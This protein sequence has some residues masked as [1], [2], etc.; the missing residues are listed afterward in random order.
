MTKDLSSSVALTAIY[1]V[2]ALV[3]ASW[4][5][6]GNNAMSETPDGMTPAEEG[7][8]DTEEGAAYGLCVSYCEATDCAD[9]VQQADPEACERLK[10]NY[11]RIADKAFP[12]EECPCK[13][14]L[15]PPTAE[16]LGTV[17]DETLELSLI[18]STST[19]EEMSSIMG[20]DANADEV[21]Y[22]DVIVR[23]AGEKSS[24]A[25]I[26]KG[27]N[28]CVQEA[29]KQAPKG[30]KENPGVAI[31]ESPR[32]LDACLTSFTQ[33]AQDAIFKASQ[34]EVL[35]IQLGAKDSTSTEIGE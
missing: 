3:L 21:M 6:F 5:L 26:V 34:R 19:K 35:V 23:D 27:E 10:N 18:N 14:D 22:Q 32:V 24:C 29:I 30:T 11:Q 8:C 16:C 7:I 33:Y 15:V 31:I 13:Y 28:P 1:Y 17:Y 25:V 20:K 2:L 12:C 4:V 9:G